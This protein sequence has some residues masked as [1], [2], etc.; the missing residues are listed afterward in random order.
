M[1]AALGES[2]AAPVFSFL[3]RVLGHTGGA[4]Q[5]VTL[6]SRLFNDVQEG[7]FDTSKGAGGNLLIDS[8]V[9]HKLHAHHKSSEPVTRHMARNGRDGRKSKI[10][11]CKHHKKFEDMSVKLNSLTRNLNQLLMPQEKTYVPRQYA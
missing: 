10:D 1:S 11:A 9:K 3:L 2:D 4:G 5:L 6:P 7:G 8:L